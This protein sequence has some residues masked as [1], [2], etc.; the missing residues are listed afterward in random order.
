MIPHEML[1]EFCRSIVAGEYGL[2]FGAGVSTDSR[3]GDGDN[4]KSSGALTSELCAAKGAPIGTSLS[5][6]YSLLSPAEIDSWVTRPFSKCKAS[7]S[8]APLPRFLW[9]RIFTFNIDDVIEDLFANAPSAK[10]ALAP[11]NFVDAYETTPNLQRLQ[12]VH[13]HGFSRRPED[14]YVFSQF[15]YAS[16]IRNGC[17]WAMTLAHSL[18]TSPFIVAGCSL[19]DE[20]DINY[21]LAAR[22]TSTPLHGRSPAIFV[23][24][25]PSIVTEKVCQQ[26]DF[27]LVKATFGEFLGWLKEQIPSPPSVEQVVVPDHRSI[28][29]EQPKSNELVSLFTRFELVRS[30]RTPLPSHPTTFLFGRPPDWPDIHSHLDIERAANSRVFKLVQR[31]LQARDSQQMPIIDVQDYAGSGKTTCI[32]R[33]ANDCAAT[34]V[35]VLSLRSEDGFNVAD[36]QQ[37]LRRLAAPALLVVDNLANHIVQV[38]QLF[39]DEQVR[40]QIVVLGSDR[41]YRAAHVAQVAGPLEAGAPSVGRPSRRELV[42]L[43]ERYRAFG[44]I[45][46]RRALQEREREGFLRILAG[47]SIAVAVCR[48]LHNFEPIR[49]IATSLWNDCPD[50]HKPVYLAAAVASQAHQSGVPS[51]ILQASIGSSVAIRDLMREEAVLRLCESSFDRRL[52]VPV[53]SAIAEEVVARAVEEAPAL[54]FDTMVSLSTTLA[55]FVNRR[56]IIAQTVEAQL[57]PRLFRQDFVAPL[58]KEWTDEFFERIKSNWSWNSRYWEQRALR[59]ID[60]DIALAVQFARQAVAIEDH[61]FP[62]T[63]LG[64]VLISQMKVE[65]ENGKRLFDEAFEE[66]GRALTLERR[67]R[68][69]TVYPFSVL[70]DGVARYVDSGGDLELR[71]YEV[72]RECC[73]RVLDRYA[74]DRELCSL[75]R[76]VLGRLD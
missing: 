17:P 42:Q 11:V 71:Q 57:A 9:Q 47:D 1:P 14:G 41:T 20:M 52:I 36:I 54:L 75:A 51:K 49:R 70:L 72:A 62:H 26:H 64:R 46:S 12:C 74:Y 15:E 13:L 66:L 4:L 55:P 48:I 34:G 53:S 25:D 30:S 32:R 7:D 39:D 67:S 43:I 58:L 21:Y 22:T 27:L 8:L 69:V 24:P 37:C 23:T 10:Q 40:R 19:I 65:P 76:S 63:T 16:R 35:P 60:R 29:R 50:S 31:A 61:P 3:N 45:G 44:L 33:V 68:R 18:A 59:E 28:F 73:S 5:A 56:T 38:M 6:V 2:L